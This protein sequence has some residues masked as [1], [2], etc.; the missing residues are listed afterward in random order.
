RYLVDPAING[1]VDVRDDGTKVTNKFDAP[2]TRLMAI[3]IDGILNQK[4]PWSLVMIG[5]V[6]AITLE[7]AGVA[8]LPFAVGVYLPIY[9]STPIFCG[10]ALRWLVEKVKPPRPEEADISPGVLLSSG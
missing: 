7:L 1:K 8:A 2:K 10:G 4:L 5:A 3:I 9:V 6:I